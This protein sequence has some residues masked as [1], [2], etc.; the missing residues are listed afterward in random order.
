MYVRREAA[1]MYASLTQSYFTQF[2]AYSTE[3]QHD[4]LNN[5]EAKPKQCVFDKYIV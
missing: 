5:S 1:C 2:R 4:F 3:F